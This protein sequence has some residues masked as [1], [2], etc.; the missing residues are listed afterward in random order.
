MK[1]KKHMFFM[2][3]VFLAKFS[4]FFK[5]GPKKRPLQ[6]YYR[7][8]MFHQGILISCIITLKLETLFPTH[9]GRMDFFYLR[10]KT[11]S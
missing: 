1:Q 4:F 2:T 6:H 9:R 10:H 11:T 5:N 3:L 8:I 7:L